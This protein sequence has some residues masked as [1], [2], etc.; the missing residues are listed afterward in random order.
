MSKWDRLAIDEDKYGHHVIV[1]TL[2]PDEAENIAYALGLHDTGA[3]DLLEAADEC[4]RL[5]EANS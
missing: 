4:R 2:D 5:N 1:A 3:R